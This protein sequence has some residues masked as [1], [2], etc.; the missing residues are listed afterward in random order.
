MARLRSVVPVL[1]RARRIPRAQWVAHWRRRPVRRDTVLYE[2]TFGAGLID[3]PYAIFRHLLAAPD[4]GHLRHVWVVADPDRR[5]R[6]SEHLRALGLDEGRVRLVGYR[7]PAYFRHLAT[8]GWLVN[9]STFPAELGKRPGQTY[10]NTWHGTP[11]KS[12]GYDVPDGALG[13]GNIIRNFLAADHLVS[14]GPYMTETMYRRAYRLEGLAPASV[15]EVGVPRTD[16][17]VTATDAQRQ[18]VRERLR[19]EGVA[20][21]PTRRTVLVAPTW[22]G[23][24]FAD[25]QIDVEGVLADKHLDRFMFPVT[26][27]PV[28]VPGVHFQVAT[29]YPKPA[30]KLARL[31]QWVRARDVDERLQRPFA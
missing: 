3:S 2:S 27:L 23:E 7:T 16:V 12:M 4:Q 30:L 20:V 6:A 9:N 1:R 8:A 17:Q 21:D 26:V 11:L 24:A 13:A 31:S 15:L 29:E 5:R 22:R 10:V 14:S 25:P 18:E 28:L 19:S